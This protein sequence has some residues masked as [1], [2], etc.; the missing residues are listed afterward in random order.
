M[1]RNAPPRY[2]LRLLAASACESQHGG[3]FLVQSRLMARLAPPA[4]GTALVRGIDHAFAVSVERR[5]KAKMDPGSRT[6]CVLVQLVAAAFA[7]V[8]QPLV[9]LA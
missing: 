4:A 3:P 7:S 9:Q 2:A 5:E 1:T 8:S 6:L